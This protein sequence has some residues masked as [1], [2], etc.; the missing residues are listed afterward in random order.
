MD[1]ED[2]CHLLRNLGQRGHQL[3][4]LFALIDVR[5]PMQGDDGVRLAVDTELP[6]GL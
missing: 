6:T 5:R 2:D 4:E 1:G 3:G